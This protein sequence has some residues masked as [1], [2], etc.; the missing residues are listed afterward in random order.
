MVV[1]AYMTRAMIEMN[2]VL[3]GSTRR[4]ACWGWWSCPHRGTAGRGSCCPWCWQWIGVIQGERISIHPSPLLPLITTSPSIHLPSVHPH[5]HPDAQRRRP[6]GGD[7]AGAARARSVA[8]PTAAAKAAAAVAAGAAVL[9]GVREGEGG[10]EGGPEAPAAEQG[11]GGGALVVVGPVPVAVP[12]RATRRRRA[13]AAGVGVGGR[14]GRGGSG[15]CRGSV[16]G[17]VGQLRGGC[18]VVGRM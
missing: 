5:A 16:A 1:I 13:A 3:T 9:G 8:A 12:P 18:V 2:T 17:G 6:K 14:G 10:R 4:Q 15:R 7:A 11:E